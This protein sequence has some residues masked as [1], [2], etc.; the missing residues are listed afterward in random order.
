M[1]D[2]NILPES[3][4]D[5]SF[6]ASVFSRKKKRQKPPENE[7]IENSDPELPPSVTT[8]KSVTVKSI[9][10]RFIELDFGRDKEIRIPAY[11]TCEIA[12]EYVNHPIFLREK[13][14]LIILNAG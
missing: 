3:E 6:E 12:E 2:E 4:E 11:A 13:H 10:N 1:S 14:N 8:F 7:P 9:V 5:N